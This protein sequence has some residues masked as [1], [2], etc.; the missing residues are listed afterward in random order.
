MQVY[1]EF[2]PTKFDARGLMGDEAG[3]SN[4]LVAPTLINRDTPDGSIER[5]NWET[6][7]IALKAIE[8][9]EATEDRS[10]VGNWQIHRFNHWGN[11]WFEIIVVRPNSD[12]ATICGEFESSLADYPILDE[13]DY[14]QRQWDAAAAMWGQM[15]LREKIGVIKSHLKDV[16]VFASRGSFEEVC[17]LDDQ[18]SLM[19]YLNGE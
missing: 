9:T 7:V 17:H 16:S 11:G 8:P 12:C 2:Q 13:E 4:W 15:D 1:K 3:I 6:I 18:G 14:S 5:S 19:T 10:L